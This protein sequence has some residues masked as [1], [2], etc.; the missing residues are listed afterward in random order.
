[1]KNKGTETETENLIGLVIIYIFALVAISLG[2][3]A[4]YLHFATNMSV[5]WMVKTLFVD[6]A[7]MSLAILKP[8]FD[9]TIEFL[10]E[11]L[12]VK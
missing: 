3:L 10:R 11:S 2:L 9:I 6:L 8:L 7:L 4:L 1:M 5:A 12:K